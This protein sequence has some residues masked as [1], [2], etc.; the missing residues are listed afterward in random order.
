MILF[1]TTGTGVTTTHQFAT[2]KIYNVKLTVTGSDQVRGTAANG[3]AERCICIS[4]ARV[5]KPKA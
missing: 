4:I 1:S 3:A 2:A 5:A